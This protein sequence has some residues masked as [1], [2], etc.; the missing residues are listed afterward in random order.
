MQR[1]RVTVTHQEHLALLCDELARVL[2]VAPHLP[3]VSQKDRGRSEG[4]GRLV[5]NGEGVYGV[6]KLQRAKGGA[7]GGQRG[8]CGT[9]V[10][11]ANGRLDNG[12]R[13]YRLHKLR[14]QTGSHVRRAK[15]RTA[16]APVDANALLP[17]VPFSWAG[18]DS[19]CLRSSSRRRLSSSRIAKTSSS[20]GIRNGFT[21]FSAALAEPVPPASDCAV[22]T[23]AV[24]LPLDMTVADAIGRGRGEGSGRAE[25]RTRFPTWSKAFA[26]VS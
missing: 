17:H 20:D 22:D 15:T 3:K 2:A 1:R 10:F 23:F 8:L 25:K 12:A 14:C 13:V 9:G 26:C 4:R 5:Q 18:S 16:H 11:A 6:T 21:I 19:W 24:D 7:Y